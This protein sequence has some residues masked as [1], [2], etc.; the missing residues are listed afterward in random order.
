MAIQQFKAIGKMDMGKGLQVTAS[1]RQFQVIIDEPE[2]LGGLD[3]GMNPV[4]LLLASLASCKAIVVK[5][6]A[7]LH[8]IKLQEISIECIGDLDPDGF[9]L[10]NKQAKKGFSH[11]K[12]I[13]HIKAENTEEEIA[14]FVAFVESNCPVSDTLLNSPSVEEEII[15]L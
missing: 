9:L 4:E 5:A 14:K 12:T 3:T 10:K 15:I 2:E 1:A 7:R 13:Y 11:I 6:F 8:R